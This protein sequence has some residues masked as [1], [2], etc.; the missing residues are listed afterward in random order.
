MVLKKEHHQHI[1]WPFI[2]PVGHGNANS[3]SVSPQM[4]RWRF[5][6]PSRLPTCSESQPRGDVGDHVEFSSDQTAPQSLH[7]IQTEATHTLTLILHLCSPTWGSVGLQKL[8]QD[9]ALAKRGFS[10]AASRHKVIRYFSYY[11]F[12]IRRSLFY[13]HFL[14]T[15]AT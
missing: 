6:S 8:R 7:P 14:R 13:K 3:P 15:L 1:E 2:Q 4:L 5:L 10:S 9:A 12:V 11:N